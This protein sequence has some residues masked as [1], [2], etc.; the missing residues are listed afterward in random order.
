M[1]IMSDELPAQ[2]KTRELPAA[3]KT[4]IMFAELKVLVTTRFNELDAKVERLEGNLALTSGEVGV[5]KSELVTIHEWRGSIE[6]RL[7]NNSQRAK[8]MTD[9]DRAQDA[10]LA[11]EITA[12][13]A[14]AAKVDVLEQ[15]TDAQTA[16]LER[17]DKIASNP[18]V[19]QIAAAAGTAILTWL[20]MK[21]LR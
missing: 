14:L 20:T 5:V 19:K 17:L 9:G 6:E 18:L 4:E 21:G 13:Q 1:V 7:K 3:D 15:K 8:A 2:P 16:I 11:Q 12:R 10:Q